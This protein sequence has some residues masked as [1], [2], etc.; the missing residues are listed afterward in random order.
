MGACCQFTKNLPMTAVN[1]VKN[2]D[3]QPRIFEGQSFKGTIMLH[4]HKQ[5]CSTG[6]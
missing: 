3:G 2:A 5:C 6:G 1:A 4:N